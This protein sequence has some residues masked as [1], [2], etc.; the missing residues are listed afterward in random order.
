M[1]YL[2]GGMVEERRTMCWIWRSGLCQRVIW[3]DSQYHHIWLFDGSLYVNQIWIRFWQFS[4]DMKLKCS[5]I[6][7]FIIKSEFFT[8]RGVT[9]G[10]GVPVGTQHWENVVT[11]LTF[12]CKVD[13]QISTYASTF[14]AQILR[15]TSKLRLMIG[16]F[17]RFLK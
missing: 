3:S 7:Q 2:E 16:C 5:I 15:T 10:G 14:A 12:G 13:N 4:L 6:F 11:T 9:T 1:Y 8:F 17:I